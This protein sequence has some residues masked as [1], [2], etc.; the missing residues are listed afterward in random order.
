MRPGCVAHRG[1]R[2]VD[3]FERTYLGVRLGGDQLLDRRLGPTRLRGDHVVRQVQ[4]HLRARRDRE[5]EKSI[6]SYRAAF[7]SAGAFI[8]LS[9][10][11]L[12]RTVA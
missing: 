12:V 1:E 4:L 2:R 6:P 3:G 5:R 8:A 7:I 10:D 9:A 11:L